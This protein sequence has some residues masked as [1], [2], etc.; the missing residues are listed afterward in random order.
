MFVLK[1][2]LL[3]NDPPTTVED[4]AVAITGLL[5]NVYIAKGFVPSEPG[6]N[7]DS[8]E[9]THWAVI[10]IPQ[11]KEFWIRSYEDLTWQRIKLGDMDFSQDKKFGNLKVAT[12][13]NVVD[14]EL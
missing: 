3:S 2:H 1:Q 11:R 13:L 14:V 7:T 10:K 8:H 6:K 5:N 9:I 12:G 4:A